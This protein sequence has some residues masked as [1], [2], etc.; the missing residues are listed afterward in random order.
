M[1]VRT[2]DWASVELT[3]K[4]KVTSETLDSGELLGRILTLEPLT[5]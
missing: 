3:R 5:N 2:A 4:T 1:C